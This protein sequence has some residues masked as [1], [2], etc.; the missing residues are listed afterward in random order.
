MLQG[1]AYALVFSIGVFK[2]H[3]WLRAEWEASDLAPLVNLVQGCIELGAKMLVFSSSFILIL[4]LWVV[5]VMVIVALSGQSIDCK[6]NV[7]VRTCME[8]QGSFMLD[9]QDVT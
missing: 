1:S 4:Q 3:I 9:V 7:V 2:L 6:P 8:V 5:V